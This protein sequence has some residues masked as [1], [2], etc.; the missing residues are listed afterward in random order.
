[1]AKSKLDEYHLSSAPFLG[2]KWQDKRDGQPFVYERWFPSAH[3]LNIYLC[4]TFG[5][6]V[7]RKVFRENVEMLP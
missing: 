7:M 5:V 1:M 6:R 2:L 3:D 4:D